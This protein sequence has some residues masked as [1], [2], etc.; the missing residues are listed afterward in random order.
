MRRKRTQGYYQTTKTGGVVRQVGTLVLDGKWAGI[1]I[2]RSTG[3]HSTTKFNTIVECLNNLEVTGNKE[4]IV[5]ASSARNDLLKLIN[6]WSNKD[7]VSPPWDAGSLSLVSSLNDWINKTTTIKARTKQSYRGNINIIAKNLGKYPDKITSLPNVVKA[8]K[9]QYQHKQ[10]AFNSMFSTS[11]SFLTAM[12]GRDHKLWKDLKSVGKFP[13]SQITPKRKANPFTPLEIENRF[14]KNKGEKLHQLLFFLCASGMRPE[15][16]LNHGFRV[17]DTYIEIFGKKTAHSERVVPRIFHDYDP[18]PNKEGWTQTTLRNEIKR[19]FPEH[20]LQDT[21]YAFANWV[22]EAGIEINR[23]T[24]YMAHQPGMTERYQ[25]REAIDNWVEPDGLKLLEYIKKALSTFPPIDTKSIKLPKTIDE[26]TSSVAY[27]GVKDIKE[28]LNK[29]LM[30]NYPTTFRRL[31]HVEKL[32][33]V[34]LMSGVIPT[35]T[36]KTTG[37]KKQSKDMDND[38]NT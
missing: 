31:Y 22:Q 20:T 16:Y 15:E 21:R 1:R 18:Q 10:V 5:W 12:V 34:P 37:V 17:Y 9:D 30:D 29:Y 6:W 24:Y 27:V 25:K 13:R 26:L 19:W 2:K 28:H 14:V 38:N 35:N 36:F 4:A 23:Y 33:E 8:L 3:T 7:K 11:G 32:V